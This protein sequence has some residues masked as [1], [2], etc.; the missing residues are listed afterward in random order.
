[1][2]RILLIISLFACICSA[3]QFTRMYQTYVV[4]NTDAD[5]SCYISGT[6]IPVIFNYGGDAGVIYFPQSNG[7]VKL[8]PFGD[9]DKTTNY[10]GVDLQTYSFV[11]N[12]GGIGTY[13]FWSSGLLIRYN[14]GV[15]GLMLQCD[16]ASICDCYTF[17]NWC[18]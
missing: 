5:A 15:R 1:M 11:D 12:D 14:S 7:S 2:K 6:G 17:S 3:E 10:R 9:K 18:N 8:T 13:L 4:C 16:M